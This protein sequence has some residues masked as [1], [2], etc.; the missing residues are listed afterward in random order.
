MTNF[1]T[2]VSFSTIHVRR[3]QWICR[4]IFTAIPWKFTVGN[5]CDC[6]KKHTKLMSTAIDLNGIIEEM[7]IKNEIKFYIEIIRDSLIGS[8]V[9]VRNWYSLKNSMSFNEICTNVINLYLHRFLVI[10]MKL[11]MFFFSWK[12]W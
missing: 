11:C 1:L 8:S 10:L 7:N 12:C 9:S 5:Q 4:Y 2:Y 6:I 3:T